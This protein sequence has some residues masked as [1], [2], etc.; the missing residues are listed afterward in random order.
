M[1]PA[2]YVRIMQHAST[3]LIHSDLMKFGALVPS[4]KMSDG[5]ESLKKM[6][7][8]SESLRLSSDVT[9]K[10][11]SWSVSYSW[12]NNAAGGSEPPMLLLRCRL[13]RKAMFVFLT[14]LT[15]YQDGRQTGFAKATKT[16]GAAKVYWK[17]LN[18][19]RI[20]PVLEWTSESDYFERF[21]NSEIFL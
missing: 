13:Q 7:D 1:Y 3:S 6:S 21:K 4:K 12:N 5:S 16:F 19:K 11:R 14:M 10:G 20:L 17:R 2:Q 15:L 18:S 8:G 9:E